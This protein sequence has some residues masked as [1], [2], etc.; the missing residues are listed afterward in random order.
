LCAVR[1]LLRSPGRDVILG[2]RA[3]ETTL[4]HLS[5]TGELADYKILAFCHARA[6][7]GQVEGL[8]SQAH[9]DPPPRG[10]SDAKALERDDGFLTSSE[11]ATLHLD[12]TGV[13]LSACNTA[14]GNGETAEAL[15]GMARAFFFAG[16]R[17][18]LVFALGGRFRRCRQN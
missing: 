10:A 3:T 16:A 13:I 18:L 1:D 11:I 12:A 5:E 9:P 14:G 8:P 6:L 15:S 7:A 4:K 2:G 17:A